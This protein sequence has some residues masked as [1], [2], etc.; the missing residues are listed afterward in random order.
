MFQKKKQD[1]KK[2]KGLALLEAKA[3]N[4]SKQKQ[5]LKKNEVFRKRNTNTRRVWAKPS[6]KR[7]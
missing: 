6:W 4:I 5:D 3:K 1:P 7:D 2:S